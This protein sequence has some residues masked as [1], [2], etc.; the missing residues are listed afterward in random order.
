[1]VNLAE[2]NG[3]DISELSLV[4]LQSIDKRIGEGVL[5][6]LDN[7]A[8]MNARTSEGG[9]ATVRTLDQIASMKTWL[10]KQA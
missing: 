10:S 2:E 7:R 8:S 3:V 1:V 4:D 5:E 9:T 6:L